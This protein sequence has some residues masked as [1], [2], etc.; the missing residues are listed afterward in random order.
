MG[1]DR[2]C[3]QRA[4]PVELDQDR[5]GRSAHQVA[6]Q[7]ADPQGGYTVTIATGEHSTSAAVPDELVG[8]T[9]DVLTCEQP[10][11]TNWFAWADH[12]L[13]E[14][15]HDQLPEPEFVN[16]VEL[17]GIAH[18]VGP[19]GQRGLTRFMVRTGP[20]SAPVIA[21]DPELSEGATVRVTGQVVVSMTR[22][23][24][25]NVARTHVVA[26]TVERVG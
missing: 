11:G 1:S 24:G 9:V 22:V 20:T 21:R 16:S 7:S 25:S 6:G 8:P 2:C 15:L 3:R 18:S 4:G 19:T 5:L 14:I 12:Y 10:D 13:T 26:D 23:G 17:V